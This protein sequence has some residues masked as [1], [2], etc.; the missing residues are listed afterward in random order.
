MTNIGTTRTFEVI[1]FALLPDRDATASQAED[2][3]ARFSIGYKVVPNR[4][5]EGALPGRRMSREGL[6]CH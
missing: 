4:E 1:R 2:L 6:L 3:S 5:G